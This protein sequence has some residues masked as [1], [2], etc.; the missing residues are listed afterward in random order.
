MLD[1]KPKIISRGE[2]GAREPKKE[3]NKIEGS[4]K[5]NYSAI[6]IHHSGNEDNKPTIKDIQNVEM[7]KRGYDDI[8]YHFAIDSDGSIYEGRPLDRVGAH[9]DGNEKYKNTI[10]IVLLA[11]LDENN[12]GLESWEAAIERRLGSGEATIP[13]VESLVKLVRYLRS[14]Y[15]IQYLGGHDEYD[16]RRFCPGNVGLELVEKMRQA[17]KFHKPGK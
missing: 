10:G 9:I 7:D 14:E 8:P 6:A 16:K 13:M 12:K 11:D 15:G 3:L 5:A 4:L 17:F 1:P 2:W